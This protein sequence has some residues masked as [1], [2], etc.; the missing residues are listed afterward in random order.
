[1][2]TFYVLGFYTVFCK[3]CL[4]IWCNTKI[5]SSALPHVISDPE[6]R[7]S[8]VLRNHMYAYVYTISEPYSWFFILIFC[9]TT[10]PVSFHF[11][12]AIR[13]FHGKPR[14]LWDLYNDLLWLKV[15]NEFFVRN[16]IIYF[17]HS[18][19]T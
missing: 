19:F 6:D 14:I 1:M 9:A 4:H 16:V 15:Q 12:L 18:S 8:M 3:H 10:C 5:I 13:V 2:K 17:A 7:G 11:Y